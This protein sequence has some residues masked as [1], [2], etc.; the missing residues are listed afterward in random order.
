[1]EESIKAWKIYQTGVSKMLKN[2]GFWL[3]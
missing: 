1:M 3:R 2:K